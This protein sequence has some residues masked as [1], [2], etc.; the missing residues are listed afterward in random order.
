MNAAE[1]L[2]EFDDRHRGHLVYEGPY[3]LT[4]RERL[5]RELA[6]LLE[7]FSDWRQRI[8]RFENSHGASVVLYRPLAAPSMRWDLIAAR[9]E[10]HDP[11]AFRYLGAPESDLRWREVQRLLDRIKAGDGRA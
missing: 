7:L 6:G 3:R 2:S 8:Y 1:L 4:G 5:G 10:G 11:L 9:F